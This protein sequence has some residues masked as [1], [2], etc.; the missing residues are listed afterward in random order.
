MALLAVAALALAAVLRIA[1]HVS[2][3]PRAAFQSNNIGVA[4]MNEQLPEKTFAEFTAA[5]RC[6]SSR[7]HARDERGVL[8]HELHS[9]EPLGKV[10]HPQ[11]QVI[12]LI[13]LVPYSAHPQDEHDRMPPAFC[14]SEHRP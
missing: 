1:A 10:R 3:V 8:Q 9:R 12:R 13:F 14:P 4:Y 11:R 6:Q 5:A 2:D 7:R